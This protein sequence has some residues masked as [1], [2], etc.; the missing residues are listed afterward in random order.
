MIISPET[1]EDIFT[2]TSLD[3]PVA[4]TVSTISFFNCCSFY[5]CALLDRQTLPF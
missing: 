3:F 4:E 5:F 1:S 2:S